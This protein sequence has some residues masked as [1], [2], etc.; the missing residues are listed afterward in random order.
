M[1]RLRKYFEVLHDGIDSSAV[2]LP[3]GPE[4][5]LATDIP[6]FDGHISFG[7]FSHVE[8]HCGYHVFTELPRLYKMEKSIRF[9]CKRMLKKCVPQ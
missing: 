1:A 3:H 8:T 2:S 9:Q 4:S 5:W 6:K 7:D